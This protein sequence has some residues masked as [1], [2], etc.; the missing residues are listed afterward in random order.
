[1]L[2]AHRT[3]VG[4]QAG[5][6]AGTAVI[7]LFFL[8][9]LVRLQPLATPMN[10]SAQFMGPGGP[11]IEMPVISQLVATT[12]FAGNLLTLTILHFLA[13]S[14][15]GVG[16]VWGCERCRIKLNVATGALY[17]LIAGSLVFYGCVALLGTN[18]LTDL[19]GPVSIAVGNLLAGAVMGGFVHGFWRTEA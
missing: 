2:S 3:K 19:P 6:L 8:L 13:F 15:L 1:M 12:I 9:D 10:L 4:L 18:V 14:I 5:V 16:A 7:V 17:G 11:L